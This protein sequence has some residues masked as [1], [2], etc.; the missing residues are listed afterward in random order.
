MKELTTLILLALCLRAH[1]QLG[2]PALAGSSGGSGASIT[3]HDTSSLW[4]RNGLDIAPVSN[5]WN[6]GIGTTTPAA[7]FYV[8]KSGYKLSVDSA[9]LNYIDTAETGGSF[10]WQPYNCGY[11]NK[12]WGYSNGMNFDTNDSTDVF[13]EIG[14]R[15]GGSHSAQIRL[16]TNTVTNEGHIH[17]DFMDTAGNR[18]ALHIETSDSLINLTT[19]GTGI[20]T[21]ASDSLISVGNIVEQRGQVNN[22]GSGTY[23]SNLTT[24]AGRLYFVED[25][26]FGTNHVRISAPESLAA[27]YNLFLPS[28]DGNNGE[29]LT[30]NGSGNLSWASNGSEVW[31]EVNDSLIRWINN[32]G[33]T[34]YIT[35]TSNG[36]GFYTSSTSNTFFERNNF[37]IMSNGIGQFQ[38]HLGTTDTIA[39]SND[40]AD[41][42][43][44]NADITT[45]SDDVIIQSTESPLSGAACTQ[46]QITWDA[47]YIYVCTASGAWKRSALTGGY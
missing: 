5:T 4:Q 16:H 19:T 20:K 38:F 30:T 35:S 24:T 27:S 42:L 46:G 17:L 12:R 2:A 21:T 32:V 28:D 33:D 14:Q 41:D 6:V 43:Y 11:N 10:T 22:I 26:S 7:K 45:F 36:S 37:Y 23:L 15:S 34:F 3:N 39:V 9:F 44:I 31:T 47:S 25:L 29:V 18:I 1:A 40:G 13:L 8:E